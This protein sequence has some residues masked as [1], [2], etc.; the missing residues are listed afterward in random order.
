M[1]WT[2]G[3]IT[4]LIQSG[5]GKAGIAPA[6]LQGLLFTETGTS[7]LTG[8]TAF[9]NRP[10][11]Q[12]EHVN[13]N[14]SIDRGLGQINNQA[15]PQVSDAQAFDPQFAIPWSAGYLSQQIRSCG[16][17]QGG[18]SKYNTGSCTG[19]VG[20]QYAGKVLAAAGP[21][22]LSP[23]GGSLPQVPW[24]LR[25]AQQSAAG[26]STQ[27]PTVPASLTGG[28]SLGDV[29]TGDAAGQAA[30]ASYSSFWGW[31]QSLGNPSLL[32]L[33][34]ALLAGAAILAYIAV[35]RMA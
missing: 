12:Q 6:L 18:L 3:Q 35:S 4:E 30:V 21:A 22:A 31:L 25:W 34:G 33:R 19:P 10:A 7:S 26:A 17:I 20:M 15:Q 28:A 29:A 24:W 8:L 2:V 27:N 16:S 1:A 5:A 11:S 9:A 13:T 14:G 23:G 32:F